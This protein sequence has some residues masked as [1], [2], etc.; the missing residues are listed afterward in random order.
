ML[1][2]FFG[3]L[4][5]WIFPRYHTLLSIE[6]CFLAYLQGLVYLENLVCRTVYKRL[7]FGGILV[8]LFF[9]AIIDF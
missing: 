9:I 4:N 5:W 1:P 6:R 2:C 3:E 8:G 7:K